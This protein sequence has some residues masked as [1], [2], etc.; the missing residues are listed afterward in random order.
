M[1]WVVLQIMQDGNSVNG[2]L[3]RRVS[4][5]IGDPFAVHIDR[6]SVS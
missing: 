6:A 1:R 5:D 4:C 2:A 3:K